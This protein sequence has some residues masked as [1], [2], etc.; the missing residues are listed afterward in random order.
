MVQNQNN[1]KGAYKILRIE[2]GKKT[3]EKCLKF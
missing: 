1:L 3:L 2:S